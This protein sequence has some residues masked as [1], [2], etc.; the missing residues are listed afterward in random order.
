MD[1][2]AS[3][4]ESATRVQ[5][6]Y[7]IQLYS[8]VGA[9]QEWAEKPYAGGYGHGNW[10]SHSNWMNSSINPLTPGLLRGT[11]MKVSECIKVREDGLFGFIMNLK[12]STIFTAPAKTIGLLKSIL[13]RNV[14]DVRAEYP[15]LLETVAV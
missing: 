8:R 11:D 9:K 2:Q 10:M 12:D 4:A 14:E 6:E 13:D 5:N 15:N 1:K 3:K 7:G